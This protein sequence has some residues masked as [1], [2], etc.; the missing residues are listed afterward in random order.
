MLDTDDVLA[1]VNNTEMATWSEQLRG[2]FCV[3]FHNR[4]KAAR[5][6]NF[7]TASNIWEAAKRRHFVS[8]KHL[9]ATLKGFVSGDTNLNSNLNWHSFFDLLPIQGCFDAHHQHRH[10]PDI[11][12]GGRSLES[13]D[14]IAKERAKTILANLPPIAKAVRVIDQV[15]AKK[16]DRVDVIEKEGEKL[17]EE[18]DEICG[19]ID[20][21]EIDQEMS[22]GAFRKMVKA[23]DDARKALLTEMNALTFEGQRL[24][25]EIG[26]A[27]FAG[28]PG[29]TDAVIEVIRSHI[30]SA[31]GLESMG[32]RVEEQVKFGNSEAAVELLRGFEKD[33]VKISEEVGK[34]F[35]IALEKLKVAAQGK[36]KPKGKSK[37]LRA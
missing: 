29:L 30:E 14:L 6:I 19:V 5:Y 28:L 34:T 4:T 33:E 27:L 2:E 16:I 24:E 37:E 32:R 13:L 8:Q 11:T 9:R 21:A 26:K 31:V 10:S 7:R 12:V 17:R 22:V 25:S 23:R 15:T 1:K 36:A 35:R 20:M 3:T 18:L